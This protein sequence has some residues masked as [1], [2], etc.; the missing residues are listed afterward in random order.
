MPLPETS[1]KAASRDG[2]AAFVHTGPARSAGELL[3]T[4]Q[5]M[6]E[7][8]RFEAPRKGMALLLALA[9]ALGPIAT[10]AFAASDA[11]QSKKSETPA[12]QPTTPIQHLVVIFNENISFDHYFGTY[13][14]ATNPKGESRFIAAA[15][16][17]TV[18]GYTSALLTNNPNL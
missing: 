2:I 6:T 14:V 3:M 7:K 13:P 10:P 16:T 18:N 17:P 12:I 5:L 1:T 4:K 9:T 15:N 11:K 8:L